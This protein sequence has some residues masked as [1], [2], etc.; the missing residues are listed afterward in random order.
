MFFKLFIEILNEKD[1]KKGRH[2]APAGRLSQAGLGSC[3]LFGRRPDAEGRF[4][5]F[6]GRRPDAVGRR[7]FE[8]EGS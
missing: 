2:C 5:C 3:F 4:F 8:K 7:N 6:F 1:L